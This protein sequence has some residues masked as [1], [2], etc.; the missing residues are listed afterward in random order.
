MER[1]EEKEKNRETGMRKDG[2]ILWRERKR[3]GIE[4]LRLQT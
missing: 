3:G 4:T 2:G 1:D